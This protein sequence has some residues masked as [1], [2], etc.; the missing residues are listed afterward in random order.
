MQHIGGAGGG[1]FGYQNQREVMRTAFALLKNQASSANSLNPLAGLPFGPA[2]KESCA[3]GWIFHCCRISMRSS[4]YFYFSVYGGHATIGRTFIQ[5]L[6][7]ATA[8][9]ELKARSLLRINQN[10]VMHDHDEIV[11]LVAGHIGHERLARF[12]HGVVGSAKRVLLKNLPAV[13]GHELV[14]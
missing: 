2:G 8:A 7:A 12:G 9:V 1:L 3:T 5:S 4:K 6:R 14:V 10:P 11:F 13:A